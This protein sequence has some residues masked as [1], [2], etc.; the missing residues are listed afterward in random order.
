MSATVSAGRRAAIGAQKV[1]EMSGCSADVGERG[2]EAIARLDSLD[3]SFGLHVAR[4]ARQHAGL[5]EPA[6]QS[7]RL[8]NREFC[9][10]CGSGSRA[11]QDLS[12]AAPKS[13][14][15][16]PAAPRA[17]AAD[18][19]RE[20]VVDRGDERHQADL[21]RGVRRGDAPDDP[22]RHALLRRE[23]SAAP[24]L[25]PVRSRGAQGGQQIRQPLSAAPDD[26][27]C[28]FS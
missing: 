8:L 21:L 11:A 6:A 5:A 23:D 12:W 22:C 27:A 9:A 24:A 10:C 28:S 3:H 14:L 15:C 19:D 20:A 18:L 7:H 2:G 4:R 26:A 17:A 1:Y 16:A 13:P 25:R